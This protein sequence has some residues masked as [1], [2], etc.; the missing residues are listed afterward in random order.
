MTRKAT[1]IVAM[2]LLGG[3]VVCRPGLGITPYDD[4]MVQQAVQ[5]I[6]QENYD[7]AIALLTQAWE[8]GTHTPE[9]AFLLGQTYRLMLNYPKA[10]EY[11]EEALRLKPNFPQAQL[12]L[13]DT[14]LAIDKPKEALPVLQKLEASGYE[15]GQT[16]YLLGM[17]LVKEGKYS[18]A[19]EYFRKAQQDPKMAQEAA[20]QASLALAALNRLK[21]AR[22]TMEKVI[23]LG[24]QTQTADFA[25]RYMGLLEKRLEELRP[26]HLG[27]TVGVDYDSNVTLQTGGASAAATSAGQGS[28]TYTQ[29]AT[30]EYNFFAGQPINV[31]TQYAYY[32]NFHM[33]IPSFDLLSHYVAVIPT[34][35]FKSGRVRFTLIYKY[36]DVGSDKYYTGYLMTPTLLYLVTPT[37]GLEVGARFNRQ[38]YW[39]PVFLSQDERTGNVF[40]NSLGLYYFFKNQKGFLQARVSYEH[41]NTQGSNWDNS[42]YRLLVAALYPVTDR[43]KINAFVDMYLQPYDNV[44]FNGETVDNVAGAPLLPQPKRYDQVIIPGL[45]ITYEMLKGLEFNVHYFFTRDASNVRLYS[46]SRHIVGCQLGYRY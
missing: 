21:E 13:A 10:R 15:P 41:D 33:R 6:Q 2:V 3:R 35:N 26:F 28:L 29:T 12:M 23:T 31:L 17:A 5:Q 36:A 20:F 19:L 46:Y 1:L 34:N 9:K 14:L 27:A 39:T 24:P 43:L 16:A 37:V 42:T 7:E 25:Q 45:Q 44:F 30:A 4:V 8:K 38:V 11:L 18:E 22:A 40:G 32:Q